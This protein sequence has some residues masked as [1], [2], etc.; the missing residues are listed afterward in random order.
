MNAVKYIKIILLILVLV[1]LGIF[2]INRYIPV[3]KFEYAGTLYS[4]KV[5][6][7]SRVSSVIKTVDVSE[8]DFINKGQLLGTFGCHNL[9][10]ETNLAKIDYNRAVSLLQSGSMSQQSF[11]RIKTKKED[12]EARL[13][14]CQIKSPLAGT[15]LTSYHEPGELAAVG[16]KLFTIANLKNISAVIYVSQS[17]LEKIKLGQK[18]TASVSELDDVEFIGTITKIN[19]EPEFTPKNVQTKKERERLVYGVTVNFA[20]SNEK[21]ILKS[22]MTIYIASLSPVENSDD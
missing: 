17:D 9:S 22:G 12:Y 20:E 2:L 13:S 21:E 19:S 6:I 4:S 10:L 1:I 3:S 14:W 18:L 7:S 8:G 11:D 15:V 5:D 16:T